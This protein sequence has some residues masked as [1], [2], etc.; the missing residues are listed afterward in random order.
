MTGGRGA[1]LVDARKL[2]R[3]FNSAPNPQRQARSIYTQ[4]SRADDLTAQERD[5]VEAF[6][7]WLSERPRVSEL[8]PRCEQL[9]AM[10]GN[11]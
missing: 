11:P 3:T 10:F 5:H 1:A 2:L 4:L 6:G 8:K 9:L 7:A